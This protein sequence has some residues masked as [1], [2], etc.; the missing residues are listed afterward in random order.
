M[1][2]IIAFIIVVAILIKII[3]LTWLLIENILWPLGIFIAEL[4]AVGSVI[5]A[6]AVSLKVFYAAVRENIDS[7]K[8]YT[9]KNARRHA[10][11]RRGYF[12]GPGFHQLKMIWKTSFAKLFEVSNKIAV[13][14]KASILHGF[15]IFFLHDLWIYIFWLVSVPSIYIFGSI[16]VFI[17]C[18]LSSIILLTGGIFFFTC[19]T[20]I[21]IADRLSLLVNSI[22][23]RCP[24]CKHVS[25]V[26]LFQCPSCGEIHENLTP[27]P[28]GIFHV[29]CSC[30]K[31]LPATAFN[32]RNNLAALCPACKSPLACGFAEQFGIQTAG[33][34][35]S[36]KTTFI[37]AF[38]HEYKNILPRNIKCS[39]YPEDDF[40][41]LD[42]Y[43]NKGLSDSTTEHNALMYSIVHKIPYHAPYQLSFYDI[44]GEAF[45]DISSGSGQQIQ[46]KYAEGIILITD[47]ESSAS[48]SEQGISSFISEHKKLK[49]LSQD[50]LSNTPAVVVISKADLFRNEF[51]SG[52][53]DES[54][55]KNFLINHGFSSV[56]NLIEANFKNIK[57]FA[58][59]AMGHK[60]DSNAYNPEG[61]KEPVL[62]LLEQGN[63]LINK[64][65]HD[66]VS[67]SGKLGFIFRRVITFA[68]S[69][70][71]STLL[72][73]G[74]YLIPWSEAWAVISK[75]IKA[76][77]NYV[78]NIDIEF[79]NFIPEEI[80]QV[81]LVNVN[82][83]KPSG[84]S[85][86]SQVK[87]NDKS[88]S[89]RNNNNNN[90]VQ[91]DNNNNIIFQASTLGTRVNLR[92]SPSML[93]NIL[94][95][96]DEGVPVDIIQ[97]RNQNDGVW[98]LVKVKGRQGWIHGDYLQ[99]RIGSKGSHGGDF[100]SIKGT[101]VNLRSS[102]DT[103]SARVTILNT[104]N[105]VEVVGRRNS[106]VQVYT[107]KGEKGW[108]FSRYVVKRDLIK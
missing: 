100:M 92:S 69:V 66:G 64:V 56:I 2:E 86:Q 52:F 30:G 34:T 75:P 80:K 14:A 13:W 11:S 43:F 22:Q 85:K 81:F 17:F 108:V 21:W 55:C 37:A 10:G 49:G 95:R 63:S 74:L 82:N 44:A 46:F 98:H 8:T 28:Y 9:D 78:A 68:P 26:P 87:N 79:S 41:K 84:S 76:T 62:W 12:F 50:A 102:P 106:W 32:G 51:A 15:I 36:G 48:K 24:E 90:Q 23:S 57:Y 105:L 77:G 39:F 60:S 93:S 97:S 73:W 27:G 35:S 33:N 58:A 25:V 19:F 54:S 31:Y 29:K 83:N 45:Q 104:G 5:F 61:V 16:W 18:A 40:K 7:Y 72:I 96:L 94:T 71:M 59:S 103:K 53:Q 88:S 6:L 1:G 65:I 89:R 91:L 67:L 3:E 42:L 70:V 107:Q 38:F 4:I 47:P 101:S 99:N 20:I